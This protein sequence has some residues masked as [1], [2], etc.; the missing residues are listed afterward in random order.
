MNKDEV[1]TRNE[2]NFLKRQNIL[3]SRSQHYPQT[4]KTL[5]IMLYHK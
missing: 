4:A 1:N 3:T 5:R 2:T